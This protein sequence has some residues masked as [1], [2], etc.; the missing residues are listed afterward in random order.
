[1][2]GK[3]PASHTTMS[4]TNWIKTVDLSMHPLLFSIR[5]EH[6]MGMI[7]PSATSFN[8]KDHA[9]IY[10][11]PHKLFMPPSADVWT[12]QDVTSIRCG[13]LHNYIINEDDITWSPM[14]MPSQ[15]ITFAQ[16]H[17]AP[18]RQ[19]PYFPPTLR[20]LTP[21]NSDGTCAIHTACQGTGWGMSCQQRNHKV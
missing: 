14:S 2:G 17:H 10:Q 18:A 8:W 7:C 20:S 15:K 3:Y 9:A 12:T 1:M 13:I 4:S 19:A 6:L 16:W 11:W 5:K 21:E